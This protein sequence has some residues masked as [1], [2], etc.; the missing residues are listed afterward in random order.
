MSYVDLGMQPDPESYVLSQ[1]LVESV[2]PL[3]EAGKRIA[4]EES[5]GSWTEVTTMTSSIFD[6]LAAKVYRVD[7]ALGSVFI[8]YP[9]ELFEEGNLYQWLSVVAGNLFGLSSLKNVRLTDVSVP[10]RLLK[11]FSGPKFG[12]EGVRGIVG[13]SRDRRPHIGCIFKPKVGLSPEE[14]ADLAY[15]V[16]KNGVDF[17]KDD[18]TLTDQTF[19]PL[20]DRVSLV[21][22]AL[23]RVYQETQRKVIYSSNITCGLSDFMDRADVAI[24]NG[25][26][27]LM[28]DAMVSGL[29]CV[30][31]LAEDPSV[32][33]PIHVHRTMHAAF[34]RNPKHGIAF[35]VMAL[36]TRIA[37]GDQLHVGTAGIG[38]MESEEPEVRRSI[39][40][41]TSGLPNLRTVFPVASG[42]IHPGLVPPLIEAM[43]K[44]VVINAGAGIWGH[45]DGGASG[46]KAMKEA[47]DA[48]M[49]GVQLQEYAQNHPALKR[50][51]DLWSR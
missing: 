33:V 16:G 43:G 42:G 8:A 5:V 37:G 36:L 40:T 13:T 18:E 47:V 35:P 28:V 3:T 21:S 31:M 2:L 38:K 1:Y 9:T 7:E 24:E 46:A 32:T 25:A 11:S 10:N 39:S 48:A 45:P 22:E 17:L 20:E 49:S 29:E 6:R 4:E 30:R 19:C 12:I 51:L 41:L 27:A 15:Q 26:T 34:T 14:M 23:D 44:D 50:A